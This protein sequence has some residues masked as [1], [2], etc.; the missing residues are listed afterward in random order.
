M[1]CEIPHLFEQVA[2]AL[3]IGALL[4]HQRIRSGFTLVD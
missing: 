3:L 2:F 1:D 4:V